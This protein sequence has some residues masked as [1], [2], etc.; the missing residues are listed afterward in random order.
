MDYIGRDLNGRA[1]CDNPLIKRIELIERCVQEVKD[2][3]MLGPN[4]LLPLPIAGARCKLDRTGG[5]RRRV[6]FLKVIININTLIYGR[7]SILHYSI[8]ERQ[9]SQKIGSDGFSTYDRQGFIKLMSETL[10][11][12]GIA[13]KKV[14]DVS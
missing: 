12:L 9:C 1:F 5:R 8:Q 2:S 14:D 3:Y 13:D 11:I 10:L 6:S 4:A 7:T